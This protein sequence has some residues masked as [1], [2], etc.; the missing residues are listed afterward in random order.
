[1][2]RKSWITLLSV[3]CAC[4]SL[5]GAD[6][7]QL[8]ADAKRSGF[9]PDAVRPPFKMKW[10]W[11]GE[12]TQLPGQPP[13]QR[14]TAK[15]G[16]LV[17]PIVAQGQVFVGAM[18]GTLYSIDQ[19]KGV[20]RWQFKTGRSIVHTAAYADGVVIANSMD[21]GV[22]GVDA[23]TGKQAW[24]YETPVGILSAPAVDGGNVYV[25]TRDG[26]A[27]AMEVKTGKLVWELDVGA[28]IVNSPAVLDGVMLF[29]S[30]DMFAHA[31]NIKTGK[32]IWKTKISGQSLRS[33]WPVA[34]KDM[35]IFHVIPS[36]SGSEM[37]LL[38]DPNMEALLDAC[39][40]NNWP[41]EREA[42]R[43]YLTEN[44][45]RQTV[46]ILDIKT[47]KPKYKEQ[48]PI[49]YVAGNM[50]P[51][52]PAVYDDQGRIYTYWRTRS[53]RLEGGGTYGTKYIPDI[54]W[55]DP[56]TGDRMMLPFGRLKNHVSVELDNNFLLTLGGDVVY[57]ANHF[58]VDLLM[59]MRDGEFYGITKPFKD[60]RDGG[61]PVPQGTSWHYPVAGQQPP[62]PGGGTNGE[63]G[64]VPA[65]NCVYINE[66]G[67]NCVSCFVGT[68]STTQPT[69]KTAE[70]S[71]R[72]EGAK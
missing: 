58:R 42:I 63:A 35:V 54:S 60:E 61:Y 46:T 28:P 43:K 4:S 6:W 26:R 62:A 20:T 65:G 67:A 55:M 53:S 32:E 23:E 5:W 41:A 21:G 3:A 7:T 34:Y 17:Q 40:P 2:L 51:P 50:Y 71:T 25:T 27:L 64:I 68:V 44:P 8:Q 59:D 15:I 39:P 29:G 16:S 38:W 69:S 24:K 31:V 18:D 33:T 66:P 70:T 22:Y 49:G 36:I 11:F 57:G 10:A 45:Q 12:A 47:G 14:A 19:E 13:P 1:M 9:S 56:A 48:P 37:Q 30:E 52:M 72:A